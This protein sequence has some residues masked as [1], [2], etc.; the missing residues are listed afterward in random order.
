[1]K[2]TQ[3]HIQELYKFTRKHY[4][5]Y[6]DVQTELVDHLANDIEK[7]WE[8]YPNLSFED[9]RDK[10]FKKFGV[11]GFMNVVDTKKVQMNK[12][13]FKIILKFAKEWFRLP[14]IILTFGLFFGFY[15]LQKISNAYEVHIAVLFG[16]FITQLIVFSINIKKQKKHNIKT[17]KKWLLDSIIKT[18]GFGSGGLIAFYTV[19]FIL[20]KSPVGFYQM[21]DFRSFLIAFVMSFLIIISYISCVVIPKK[22]TQ[23]LEETYPEYKLV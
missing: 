11:F 13:Y 14:K 5:E 7:I 6:Y 1:M 16:V 17:N 4:V 15:Q 8:E 12:K 20:P 22:A 21:D 23:L 19:Q 9:A 2:L 3:N 10:S 18:Q